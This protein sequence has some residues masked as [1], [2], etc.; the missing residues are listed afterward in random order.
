MYQVYDT[1]PC[2]THAHDNRAIR[3]SYG[4]ILVSTA[5]CD[6]LVLLVPGT[7][8]TAVALTKMLQCLLRPSLPPSLPPSRVY[9]NLLQ[10]AAG[11]RFN[12]YKPAWYIHTVVM[13]V[14]ASIYSKRPGGLFF[15]ENRQKPE[16]K[17]PPVK[18]K[19]RKTPPVSQ[20]INA[21]HVFFFG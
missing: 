10:S 5:V 3:T 21:P 9:S 6:S 13:R 17:L 19:I 11:P 18:T 14:N 12:R 8:L 1:W 4:C 2:M 20:L 15:G 7:L 16:Y